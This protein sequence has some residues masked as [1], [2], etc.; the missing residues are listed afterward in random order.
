MKFHSPRKKILAQISNAFFYIGLLFSIGLFLF[1]PDIYNIS[2]LILYAFLST[3]RFVK[4]K[5]KSFGTIKDKL[6][7]F[8]LSFAVVRVYLK[9]TGKEM[10]HRVADE[11]GHYYCL[12]SKGNY[13]VTI[14]KKNNDESYTPVYTSDVISAKRGIINQDFFV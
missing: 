13:Y 1:K 4:L 3:I 9:S 12:I 14:E 10:F 7:G 6:S 11:Y 8:P 2:I 5:P